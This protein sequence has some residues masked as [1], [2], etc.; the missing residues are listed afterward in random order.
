MGLL[1]AVKDLRFKRSVNASIGVF[2][3]IG[4]DAVPRSPWI[5]VGNEAGSESVVELLAGAV[6]DVKDRNEE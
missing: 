2:L 3:V 1:N 5:A 6:T 4:A